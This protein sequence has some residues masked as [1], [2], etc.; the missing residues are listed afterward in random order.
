MRAAFSI[1]HC[2][3]LVS[4]WVQVGYGA[5]LDARGS[6]TEASISSTSPE[7]TSASGAV[8]ESSSSPA[9]LGSDIV[10][11]SPSAV[12][13]VSATT[14]SSA[15]DASVSASESASASLTGSSDSSLSSSAGASSASPSPSSTPSSPKP[16]T[17]S[18]T[19]VSSTFLDTFSFE[20]FEDPTLGRVR[21]VNKS[22]ALEKGLVSAPADAFIM[23]ADATTKLT[24]DGPGRDSVRIKSNKQYSEHVAV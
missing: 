19:Y 17:L 14:S 15:A 7:T 24:A 11:S 18:D 9:S 12:T 23:R 13:S 8:G 10:S 22:Y 3:L 6:T 20:T 16:Y 21:Y 2:A 5:R 1:L 4:P